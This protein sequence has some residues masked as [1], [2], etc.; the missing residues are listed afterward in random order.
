MEEAPRE[1]QSHFK[2]VAIV[3]FLRTC[4]DAHYLAISQKTG[5]SG[6]EVVMAGRELIFKGVIYSIVDDDAWALL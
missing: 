4:D 1:P 2:K 5:T 6:L 3:E